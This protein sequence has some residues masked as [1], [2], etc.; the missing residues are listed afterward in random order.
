MRSK[1][2]KA[3]LG[4]LKDLEIH[5]K[6]LLKEI[7]YLGQPVVKLTPKELALFKKPELQIS[8]TEISVGAV[9]D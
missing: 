7:E 5:S 2:Q 4:E 8:E 9:A 3:V 1:T 6:S